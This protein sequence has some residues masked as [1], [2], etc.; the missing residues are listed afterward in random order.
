MRDLVT[1]EATGVYYVKVSTNQTMGKETWLREPTQ[2]LDLKMIILA[3]GLVLVCRN[4]RTLRRAFRT[5][6]GW[7][8]VTPEILWVYRLVFCG[9]K[10]LGNSF[11]NPFVIY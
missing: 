7:R 5:C 1:C 11:F 10:I 2:L 3:L 9:I 4:I 8:K 6:V